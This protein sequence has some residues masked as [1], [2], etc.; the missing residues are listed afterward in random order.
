MEDVIK[1]KSS[2]IS[3]YPITVLMSVYNGGKYLNEAIDSILNQTYKKFKFLII[4]D[5]ST[6]NTHNIILSYTDYRI[7]YFFNIKNKGLISS[8]NFGL[9]NSNSQYIARM[10]ADDISVNNRLELQYNFMENNPD[11]GI[12]G[13]QMKYFGLSSGYSAYPL[14]D[15]ECRL[16][17]LDQTCFSNN[18]FIIRKKMVDLHCLRFNHT[19][20]HTEDYR[21]YVDAL[22]YMKGA[23]LS[24]ILTYYRKHE[25]SVTYNNLDVTLENRKAIRVYYLSLL[26]GLKEEEVQPFYS[27]TS[28]KKLKSFKKYMPLIEEKFKQHLK[29]FFIQNVWYKDSLFEVKDNRSVLFKYLLILFF[30]FSPFT[31][32]RYSYLLKH[33]FKTITNGEK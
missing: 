22:Q 10:D 23:N 6:D 17:L 5:G 9:E 26:L 28:L 1:I 18:L 15:L 8:L 16:R 25:S 12:S 14:S 27:T 7:E 29:K 4:N 19:F 32:I 11:I 20:L 3:D 2:L 31:L 33:Y 13:G 30:E 24:E 21:F